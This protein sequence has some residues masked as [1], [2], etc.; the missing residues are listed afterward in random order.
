LTRFA[1]LATGKAL[2][3]AVNGQ[4][5]HVTART[6]ERERKNMSQLAWPLCPVLLLKNLKIRERDLVLA[7]TKDR[8][9]LELFL[10][11]F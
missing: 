2:V 9:L 3:L 1:S 11:G 5:M 10:F 4:T 7:R 6:P 8:D